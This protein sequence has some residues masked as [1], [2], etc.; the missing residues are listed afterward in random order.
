[1]KVHTRDSSKCSNFSVKH[2]APQ[3]SIHSFIHPSSYT[4]DSI[5]LEPNPK[6]IYINATYFIHI[7]YTKQTKF[8]VILVSLSLSVC[9]PQEMRYESSKMMMLCGKIK[10]T[11]HFD[12]VNHKYVPH[13]FTHV[14]IHLEILNTLQ[15]EQFSISTL[16]LAFVLFFLL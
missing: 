6:C 14:A 15:S 12:I 5:S 4:C 1:M 8:W 9:N 7:A 13:T 16:S 2:S 3:P 10:E 11:L